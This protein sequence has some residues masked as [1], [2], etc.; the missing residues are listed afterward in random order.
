MQSGLSFVKS[1]L[2]RSMEPWFRVIAVSLIG[3]ELEHEFA[4]LATN[5]ISTNDVT[6]H[7]I[8]LR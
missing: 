7:G 2:H 8:L 1:V 6:N 5:T 3:T 4:E